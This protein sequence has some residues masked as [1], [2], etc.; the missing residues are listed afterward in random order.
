MNAS[1]PAGRALRLG[2]RLA[3][4]A[5]LAW[6]MA[7]RAILGVGDVVYDPSNT[8]E[9]INLLRQAQQEFDRLGSLLGVSTREFDQL[10]SLAAALG[11]PTEAAAF[12][13]PL[14]PAALQDLVRGL[15]GL[16]QADLGSLLNQEGWIDAFFGQAP[17]AWEQAVGQPD[18]SYRA[19]LVAPAAERAGGTGAPAGAAADYS[20]WYSSLSPED[21]YTLAGRAAV[22]FSDLLAG[23]WLGRDL[24]RRTNLE[25]LAAAAQAARDLAARARTSADQQRAQA[26]IA[27]GTN[28]I[29]LQS[30]AQGAEAA[31]A[32]VRA[33]QAE[34]RMLQEEAD[35][36]RAEAIVRLDTAP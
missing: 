18:A 1:G 26:Q 5:A 10:V 23:D 36:R 11:D 30:A 12:S 7:A 14:T 28:G 16:G 8:A 27:A 6:P 34:V 24:Q 3:A 2:V 20:R 19:I 32:E 9:T 17:S 33:V 15:P 29:L 25:G 31:E 4:A 35:G 21:Q 22:D 13:Q